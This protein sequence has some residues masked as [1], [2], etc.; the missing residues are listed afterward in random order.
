M[1]IQRLDKTKE[2]LEDILEIEEFENFSQRFCEVYRIE[3]I[4]MLF[5]IN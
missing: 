5:K 1:K 3:G 2:K 4:F